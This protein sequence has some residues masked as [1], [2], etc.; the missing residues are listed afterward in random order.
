LKCGVIQNT[1]NNPDEVPNIL[2]CAWSAY[3]QRVQDLLTSKNGP[4]FWPTL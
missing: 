2:M 4:V 3:Y 1:A